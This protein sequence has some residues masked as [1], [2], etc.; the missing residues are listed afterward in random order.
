MK[1]NQNKLKL[2]SIREKHSKGELI[3]NIL[4]NLAIGGILI[5]GLAMP[6]IV[7]LLNFFGATQTNER[8]KMLKAVE[9]MK[10]KKLVRIYEKNGADIIEITELGKKKVL[11]YD[12]ENI[13]ITRPKKWDGYWRIIIFDIPEKNKKAR[14]ALNFKLKDMEFFPLQKSVFVCPFECKNEIEFVLEFFGV[15][16]YVR[17]IL[18]KN[19]E[20]D[21]FLKNFFKL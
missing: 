9:R 21:E 8:R 13:K 11:S 2:K 19:I 15:K 18:A 5:S 6:N 14:R 10:Q 16:R 3:K 17:Q 4:K 7:Q 1:N 12:L 20:N